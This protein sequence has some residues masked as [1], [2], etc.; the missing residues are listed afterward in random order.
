MLH[1]GSPNLLRVVIP[2]AQRPDHKMHIAAPAVVVS[3][4]LFNERKTLRK[5]PGTCYGTGNYYSSYFHIS[6]RFI[7]S[8][9][10]KL[11]DPKKADLERKDL[12][13]F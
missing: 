6:K 5:T 8:D 10:S 9:A 13:R 12:L 3:S 7:N 2:K 1:H 4:E 11:G